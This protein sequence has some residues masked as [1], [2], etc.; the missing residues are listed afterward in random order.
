MKLSQRNSKLSKPGKG[1]HEQPEHLPLMQAPS[2]N[3]FIY[4]LNQMGWSLDDEI[5]VI[6]DKENNRIIITNQSKT[7]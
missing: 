3:P 7:L 2:T 4:A 6:T 1:Q 5:D